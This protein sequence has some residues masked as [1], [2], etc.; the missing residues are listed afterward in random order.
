MRFDIVAAASD[1]GLTGIGE[2]PSINDFGVVAFVGKF[3]PS[4]PRPESIFISDGGLVTDISPSTTF[5]YEPAVQINNSNQIISRGSTNFTNSL[6][7]SLF[8]WDG[9]A[10]DSQTR[11]ASGIPG[12][13]A[14]IFEFDAVFGFPAVN[15]AGE[16]VFSANIAS[17]GNSDNFLVTPANGGF[18]QV[19][20]GIPLRPM[21]ADNGQVIVR[22]GQFGGGPAT[23]T[24][25]LYDAQLTSKQD[26]AI[27]GAG[28]SELGLSPGIS[29]DG[30]VIAFYGN[31]D[32]TFTDNP[33]AGIFISFVDSGSRITQRVAG[34]S[35]NGFLDPGETFIDINNN[36]VFDGNEVDLGLFT[37][38]SADTRVGV[39][40]TVENGQTIAQLAYLG[41]DDQG[42]E[43]LASTNIVLDGG[44]IIV[45]SQ[46]LI[47]TGENIPGLS[48][49]IQDI[50]IYDPI[51]ASG[52]VAFWAQT[53]LGD[54]VVIRA[55]RT[56]PLPTISTS[57]D[58]VIITEGDSGTQLQQLEVTLSTTSAD[59]VTVDY[60]TSDDTAIAGSDYI[61]T[62]GTLTFAPGETTKTIDVPVIGDIVSEFQERYLITLSNP[63]NATL[64][65]AQ[66]Q[67]FIIDN[68]DEPTVSISDAFVTVNA[69][70]DEEAIITFE[71][72]L[73]A[74]SERPISVEYSTVDGIANSSGTSGARD[75]E[76]AQSQTLTFAPG[77][78]TKTIEIRVFGEDAVDHR[79]FE[80][81]A[82]DTAY[83][84]WPN[85]T[86]NFD[87]DPE[88]DPD[89]VAPPEVYGDLGYRVSR[90]F[91]GS[92]SDYQGVGLVSDENFFI[93]LSAPIN[94]V[95]DINEGRA[96]GII[97]DLGKPPV[98]ASRGTA[99]VADILSDTNPTAIGF[100]QFLEIQRVVERWLNDV[101]N[102]QNGDFLYQPNFTGH[103]LGGA[104][105]QLLAANYSTSANNIGEIVT[106]NSP[107]IPLSESSK[108]DEF[109]SQ[110][111]ITHYV[112][113]SDV[114]SMAGDDYLPGAYVLADYD[115]VFELPGILG[116]IPA[117]TGT[118]NSHLV[119]TIGRQVGYNEDVSAGPARPDG[120]ETFTVSSDVL[121]SPLFTF[122][123]DT[124]YFAF[125][126]AIQKV[127]ELFASRE[128]SIDIA[129][130][131]TFR[132]T[133]ESRRQEIGEA[134]R[135]ALSIVDETVSD[136]IRQISQAAE[137]AFS[138]YSSER[139]NQVIQ[140][141][142]RVFDFLELND[143]PI[144]SGSSNLA[145]LTNGFQIAQT[146]L[147]A[148][149]S[150]PDFISQ[151]QSVFGSALNVAAAQSLAQAWLSDDFSNLAP[152]EIVASAATNGASGAYSLS[153]NIIYLSDDFVQSANAEQIATVLLEEIGHYIDTQINEF[154]TPG[155]EGELFSAIARNVA[156]TD[157][158]IQAIRSQDDL[159]VL[160]NSD[161]PS[162]WEAFAQWTPEIWEASVDWTPEAFL[163][164][165]QNI[166]TPPVVAETIEDQSTNANEVFSFTIASTIFSDIDAGDNLT[167]T[168]TLENGTAL[169]NWLTFDPATQTFNGVP[170]S[171]DA[172]QL[173]IAVTATDDSGESATDTFELN[174]D[175]VN[176]APVAED[177]T[178]TTDE[179]V[180]VDIAVLANDSDVD[181]N[182]LSITSID[183]TGTIGSVTDNGD[184]TFT[185]DP[186]DE[187]D[188]E[189]GEE[190]TDSFTYTIS[191]GNGGESTATVFITINGVDDGSTPG[192][193]ING[194]AGR[195]QL[196]GTDGDDVI[197][198]GLGRDIITT[199]G[200]SDR[201]VYD[202]LRDGID[203]LSDF[204]PLIDQIG[205]SGVLEEFSLSLDFEQAINEGYL[206]IGELRGDAF[207][208]FDPDGTAGNQG[209][210]VPLLLV[211]GVTPEA[212]NNEANF[213][214]G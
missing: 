168:A 86:S 40:T 159:V 88:L 133:V 27:I 132:K 91:Q 93:D 35:N 108:F 184:G 198:G 18:N 19:E 154:D 65:R 84:D 80:I 162:P 201:I 196:I 210:A 140:Q 44:P 105:T 171:T 11:I 64:D 143:I 169:P 72:M 128:D 17:G 144:P 136:T 141:I 102:P 178:A 23:E 79:A 195:D 75:Y 214:L 209:R 24:L 122:L 155:D 181:G 34:I 3:D 161:V 98:L 76:A 90:F 62:S 58:A 175:P 147:T 15:N 89:L 208:A 137:E 56:E 145:T 186:D 28:F 101:S 152:I 4:A 29:D 187:F 193:I 116:V 83:R 114:V 13:I 183:T 7:N 127:V 203:I 113:S 52:Q 124:D 146:A 78:T 73:S 177:D 60:T 95:I 120:I 173:N 165:I 118:L 160:P 59:T 138:R 199:G 70:R 149:A 41:A 204:T 6:L 150:E 130:A 9:N 47:R 82:K 172:G 96:E 134:I 188:L 182:A 5:R 156:L 20:L 55:Q 119:P 39:S 30:Q 33:G 205:L 68:D 185:Y 85:P 103:S 21:I 104:L 110:A 135:N 54:E 57:A 126:V 148:L 129:N 45:D 8:L 190:A 37:S 164:A 87:P 109:T 121:S 81:F 189:V 12:R 100:D 207:A 123:P 97:Y 46:W 10:Q 66:T 48:G 99:G 74:A 213:I 107:G 42:E 16:P 174:V 211:Q 142:E 151:M 180:A 191:D 197:T 77:E 117:I 131:L 53:S 92:T 67:V 153:R 166:N 170:A 115:S 158:E 179:D 69:G 176:N 32:G 202:S 61:A 192:Q 167:Y 112:T 200:G 51:N 94:A 139:K 38:F 63:A 14:P 106:F 43:G 71:V 157:A 36:G 26:I 125:Q 1:L 50:D 163:T 49:S 212:L 111:L 25:S 22:S 194:T 2:K 31:S 206:Q